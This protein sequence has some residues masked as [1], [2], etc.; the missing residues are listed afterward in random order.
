MTS[1]SS[2]FLINVQ[3]LL[4]VPRLSR[5]PKNPAIQKPMKDADERKKI[6][7]LLL[8]YKLLRLSSYISVKSN[9]FMASS[10]RRRKVK[11]VFA[12]A[13][14]QIT[15]TVLL[16]V[17]FATRPFLKVRSSNL[18]HLPCF[19]VVVILKLI[20]KIKS[21]QIRYHTFTDPVNKQ[22]YFLLK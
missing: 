19:N 7:G 5:R 3:Q 11:H 22:T 1:K 12:K 20:D 10:S 13:K 6:R 4:P 8:F 21:K 18:S 16:A 9:G 2:L 17:G 14:I 15:K